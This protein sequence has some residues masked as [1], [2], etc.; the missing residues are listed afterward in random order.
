MS[1]NW[2]RIFLLVFLIPVV[3]EAG[4]IITT[5]GERVEGELKK[6][7][8][9]WQVTLADGRVREIRAS[10][11]QSIELGASS[12]SSTPLQRLDSLRRS[13][14]ALE[15]I[16]TIIDRYRRFIEQ[17]KDPAAI[18]LALND[19][20]VWQ[21]RLEQGMVKVGKRWMTPDERHELAMDLLRRVDLARQQ[22]KSRDLVSSLKTVESIQADDPDSPSAAYLLGVIFQ[23]QGKWNDSETQFQRVLKSVPGHAPTLLNLAVLN[24]HQKQWSGA[25]S[26]MEQALVSE[27]GIQTLIDAAAELLEMVPDDQKKTSSVQKLLKRFTEQDQVLQKIMA[28]RQMFRWGSQWIDQATRQQLAE[29]EQ[30][31]KLRLDELQGDFDLT[32][33]RI[34]RID[35][36]I[37]QNEQTLRQIEARSFIRYPDGSYVRVP[38]PPSYYDIQRDI[39]RL[40]AERTEMSKRLDS[41][42]ESAKRIMLELPI[43]RYTGVITPIGEDGVP[44]LL[45]PGVQ[46]EDLQWN[47]QPTTTSTKPTSQ[48]APPPPPV[49][50]IG[51]SEQQ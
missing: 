50:E 20:R 24:A 34:D 42:R 33:N 40:R 6:T 23:Q 8:T 29:T 5:L 47:D 48:P 31:I 14:E 3:A 12:G 21:D 49:I 22:I 35:F 11:V 44:V 43:P 30:K 10:E 37:A 26:M 46:P 9:G 4:T 32:R 27:P 7:P 45:P 39:N 17:I 2:N 16:P 38:Y 13:V 25:C 1:L 28:D 51:P 19:L 15:D 18:Q 36:E 41:L